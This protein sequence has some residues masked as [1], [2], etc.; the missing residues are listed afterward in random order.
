MTEIRCLVC[1]GRGGAWTRHPDN[2]R[3]WYRQV[4]R[5]CKGAGWE[6]NPSSALVA[7]VAD[8]Q[9]YDGFTPGGED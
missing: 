3:N 6:P 1:G 8:L 7:L 9:D 4:C 2:F 5:H